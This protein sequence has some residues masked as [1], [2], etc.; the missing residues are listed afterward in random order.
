MMK[1]L[2][3]VR[4]MLL[5]A[6]VFSMSLTSCGSDDDNDGTGSG[7]ATLTV[8][9][10]NYSLPYAFFVP[11]DSRGGSIMFSSLN[12]LNPAGLTPSTKWTYCVL[13]FNGITASSVPAGEHTNVYAEC[14]V[15]QGL[16]DNGQELG[17]GAIGTA[18]VSKQGNGYK[19]D[20]TSTEITD[21]EGSTS[22]T[23]LTISFSGTL[24]DTT[25]KW[26]D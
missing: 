23:S 9:G 17:V 16:D 24:T 12:I 3:L 10:K 26:N 18:V 6:V 19:I 4:M 1:K 2:S 14:H 20:F 11:G 7:T 13:A 25:G 22:V 8:S 21:V 15:N 5:V